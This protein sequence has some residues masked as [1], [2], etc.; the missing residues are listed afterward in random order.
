MGAFKALRGAK[1][2]YVGPTGHGVVM[3]GRVR[4][5]G[6]ALMAVLVFALVAGSG[7]AAASTDYACPGLGSLE[8]LT[9]AVENVACGYQ[10]LHFDT[11]GSGNVASGAEALYSNT[12]GEDNV[13]SGVDSLYSNKAGGYN[14]ASGLGA[15]E[16]NTTG[17][18]NVASG[19]YA[20]YDNTGGG[21]NV[22]SGP[23]ALGSNE[24]GSDNVASGSGALF[25]NTTGENNAAIGP[26]ALYENT[27][28]SFNVASGLSALFDNTTGERNVALGY[29][30][31]YNPT[32]SNNI[33]IANEGVRSDSGV[34]RIGTEGTQTEAFVAGVADTAVKG[35]SVQVTSA[36]QLGCN[37]NPAG[38]AIAT[39]AST[40]A[41]ASGECLHFTGRATPGVGACPKATSGYSASVL[42][43]L[44]MPANG[45]TV[46]N[47]YAATS[48]TVTGGDTA[49]VEVIDNTTGAKLLSCTVN[50]TSKNNCSNNEET[51]TPA[52]GNKLEVKITTS[53]KSGACKDWEV[54]FRSNAVAASRTGGLGDRH[55]PP[56][57]HYCFTRLSERPNR[58]RSRSHGTINSRLRRT[59]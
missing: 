1:G 2:C 34:T 6:L 38:S 26:D 59:N 16:H 23:D 35:C 29:R 30:A 5:L 56:P 50:S 22:A 55:G 8:K 40:A 37:N 41:V 11:E 31:G 20:L 3:A 42:L 44:A 13:A 28:G 17:S 25:E 32:G 57:A 47:L 12:T 9:T 46:S 18:D 33:E 7:S 45:A 48:A 36:G 58:W 10:A 53:G 39:F 43:S 24:T 51:G 14:V 54:T 49:T 52:A 21:N 4:T 19:R 27:E 15:L